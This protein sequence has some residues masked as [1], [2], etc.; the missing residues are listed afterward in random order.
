MY[1]VLQSAAI[2]ITITHS[3]L[4]FRAVSSIRPSIPL[5]RKIDIAEP[6]QMS[7]AQGRGAMN[8]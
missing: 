5:S 7:A 8:Q 4:T 3:H 1:P 6:H 2:R